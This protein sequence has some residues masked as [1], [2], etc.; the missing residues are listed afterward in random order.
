MVQQLFALCFIIF[1]KPLIYHCAPRDH[2]HYV[3]RDIKIILLTNW[4]FFPQT[5][6]F[7]CSTCHCRFWK[8]CPDHQHHGLALC[9]ELL[10][11][12]VHRSGPSAEPAGK[13][14][15]ASLG[16]KPAGVDRLDEDVLEVVW[17]KRTLVHTLGTLCDNVSSTQ[18]LWCASGQQQSSWDGPKELCWK[19]ALYLL[20]R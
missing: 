20:H 2:N 17:W 5:S 11:D 14:P 19:T 9:S 10:Q 18:R 8:V 13:W 6:V 12:Y 16:D 3:I 4:A 15:A 1:W 7:F